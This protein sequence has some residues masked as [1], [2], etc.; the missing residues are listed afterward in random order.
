LA[1]TIEHRFLVEPILA[2]RSGPHSK[3]P[4]Q[5]QHLIFSRMINTGASSASF[6]FLASSPHLIPGSEPAGVPGGACPRSLRFAH[7][8]QNGRWVP[9]H[10]RS[11]FAMLVPAGAGP[12]REAKLGTPTLHALRFS[13][14][15]RGYSLHVFQSLG[16]IVQGGLQVSQMA[17]HGGSL[18]PCGIGSTSYQDESY[19]PGLRHPPLSRGH[20]A[21]RCPDA[22]SCSS[23]LRRG[24]GAVRLSRGGE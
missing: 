1:E 9:T 16:S 21:C 20:R 15:Q 5:N 3:C 12:C 14:G 6:G 18:D 22:P 10:L 7:R 8:P 17:K 4:L 19:P 23:P 13:P 11:L 2:V 24:P